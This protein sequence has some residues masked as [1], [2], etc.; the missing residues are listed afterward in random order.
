LVGQ[1]ASSIEIIVDSGQD[2]VNSNDVLPTWA[3]AVHV[4]DKSGRRIKGAVVVFQFPPGAGTIA[5]ATSL[6][7]TTDD[8]GNAVARGFQRGR[9]GPFDIV[10][11]ASYQGLSATTLVHQVNKIPFFTPAKIA[12]ISGI[13]VGLGVGLGVGLSGNSSATTVALGQGSVGPAAAGRRRR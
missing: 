1:D 4:Q 3:V 9:K 8:N 6:T 12:V 10:V 2:Q 5:G 11:T 7:L 13:A